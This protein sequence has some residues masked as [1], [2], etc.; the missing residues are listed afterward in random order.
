METKKFLETNGNKIFWKHIGTVL[1]INGNYIGN[2][3]G[4]KWKQFWK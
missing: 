4:N 1:E 3:F 2:N